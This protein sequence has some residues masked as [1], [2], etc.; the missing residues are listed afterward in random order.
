MPFPPELK[1]KHWKA[2]ELIEEQILTYKDIAIACGWK[3]QYLYDLLEGNEQKCGSIVHLF[4]AELDKVTARNTLKIRELTK[5]NKRIALYLINDRLKDLK[6]KK[7]SK[8]KSYEVAKIAA[9]LGKMSPNVEIGSLSITKNMTKQE[10]ENEFKRLTALAKFALNP[11]GIQRFKQKG[12][13]SVPG[14]SGSGD[15]IQES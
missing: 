11:K 5:D 3:P 14:T 9:V 10:L 15:S 7:N 2:L 1:P 4:K 12:P 6:Q 8:E 13:G